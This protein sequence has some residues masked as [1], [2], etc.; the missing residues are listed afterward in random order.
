MK[1]HQARK[2]FGQHFLVDNTVIEQIV[3]AIAPQ[4][5]DNMVEIGPGLTALTQPLLQ[6]LD[7]LH[8]VEI[9]RDLS[10]QLLQKYPAQQMTVHQA[11]AL[12]FDF[13]SLGARL[14]IVGNLPYNISSP[15]LFHL[16]T[17]A[18]Q[19]IDQHF[20]LQ[21]EVVDRMVATPGSKD[22]SRLSVMLQARYRMMSLFDVPPESFEPPPKVDSAIVRMLPL[23]A[24]RPQAKDPALFHK[25]VAQAFT[26][27]RK[28]LRRSLADWH[29]DYAALQIAE[30]AR[31]EE[32]AVADFIK[33]ADYVTQHA[34]P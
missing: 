10:A 19:V 30:T 12:R 2:R 9:D 31:P 15:L 13:A 4:R 32:L 24:D 21:K 11:D 8:V 29:I 26:Q 16:M 23:G 28:M 27:R 18:D 5:Q 25:I 3:R 17:V 1:Q 6:Q 33:L 22:Y 20:M 34:R 14:R 7:H